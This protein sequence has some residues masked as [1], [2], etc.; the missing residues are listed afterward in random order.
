[1]TKGNNNGRSTLE[2]VHLADQRNKHLN[3]YTVDKW[4]GIADYK[5][6]PPTD[7]NFLSK[8]IENIN[9]FGM[10]NKITPIISDITQAA[11]CF[12]DRTIFLF[13][14]DGSH[15]YNSVKNNIKAWLP[16]IMKNGIISGHDYVNCPGVKQAV[17]EVFGSSVN[18]CGY[19]SSLCWWVTIS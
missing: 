9:R 1:M 17:D 5:D 13:F 11:R 12:G 8:F 15:D 10:S 4:S 18:F 2:L 14:L 7:P 3:V 16:K 6:T 19:A